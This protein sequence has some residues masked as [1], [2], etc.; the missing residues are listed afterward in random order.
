MCLPGAVSALGAQRY[1]QLPSGSQTPGGGG[2]CVRACACAC[3]GACARAWLYV[4]VC[5][6]GCMCVCARVRVCV[7]GGCMEGSAWSCTWLLVSVGFASKVNP[8][9]TPAP[10]DVSP[11]IVV[12]L[13]S[14]PLLRVTPHTGS[15]W[16]RMLLAAES[17]SESREQ[18]GQCIIPCEG[19]PREGGRRAC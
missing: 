4:R 9:D 19:G 7:C 16:L 14:D 13:Y 17:N 8:G 2:V 10:E 18:W 5:F 6:C 15:V 1:G 3:V 12:S 11:L